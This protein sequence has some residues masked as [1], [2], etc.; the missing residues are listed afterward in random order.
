MNNEQVIK[1][2]KTLRQ[3]IL[4]MRAVLKIRTVI[5]ASGIRVLLSPAR[6]A[7]IMKR[8]IDYDSV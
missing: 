3:D 7:C 2:K 6:T 1:P 4:A 8:E 5:S